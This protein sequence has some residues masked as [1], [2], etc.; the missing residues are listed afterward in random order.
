MIILPI[1]N[2][3]LPLMLTCLVLVDNPPRCSECRKKIGMTVLEKKPD[4]FVKFANS[5]DLNVNAWKLSDFES[6]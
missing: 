4:E 3:V 6:H 5:D 2:F 1:I